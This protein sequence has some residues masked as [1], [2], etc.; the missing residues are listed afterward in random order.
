MDTLD[1]IATI[2]GTTVSVCTIINFL[3]KR[4]R[5]ITLSEKRLSDAEDK[6][7]TLPCE[8]NTLDIVELRS[9]VRSIDIK[10]DLSLKNSPKQLNEH[11]KKIFRDIDGDRVLNDNKEILFEAIDRAQPATA[12]DVEQAAYMALYYQTTHEM[13]IPIKNYLYNAPYAEL[14]NNGQKVIR[15][16]TIDDACFVLSIPL[17]DMYLSEHEF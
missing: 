15:E 8:R 12:Y 14:E 3:L 6:I 17:R 1:I 13:F 11:G 7:K 2:A 16:L 4:E 10:P 5:R 9:K